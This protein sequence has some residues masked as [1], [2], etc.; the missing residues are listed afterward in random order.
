MST[1]TDSLRTVL[2]NELVFSLQ[3]QSHHWNVRGMLFKPL[4]EFFGEI[5]AG[6]Y[7]TVDSLAEYIRMEG[8]L[9][10]A[11]LPDI[12]KSKSVSEIHIVPGTSVE[13]IR[14]AKMINTE[15]I[16]EL[17]VLFNE[18]STANKQGLA[19][20]VSSVLDMHNKWDWMLTSHLEG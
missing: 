5:Y 15:I 20:Y 3:V 4:H 16:A 7:A 6:A 2:A 9:A 17:N 12:Y 8:E 13:M 1:L 19:D 18:A 11:S 10:P 14:N